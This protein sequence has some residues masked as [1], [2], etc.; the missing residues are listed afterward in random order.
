MNIGHLGLRNPIRLLE[1]PYLISLHLRDSG[2]VVDSPIAENLGLG[3][4]LGGLH[5]LVCLDFYQI[6]EIPEPG[7][8]LGELH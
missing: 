5:S 3:C 8:K 1:P 6:V 2:T 4:R 7:G